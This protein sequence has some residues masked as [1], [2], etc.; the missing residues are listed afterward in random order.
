MSKSSDGIRSKPNSVKIKRHNADWDFVYHGEGD[1]ER[2]LGQIERV[3]YVNTKTG[4]AGANNLLFH[5]HA[6]VPASPGKKE[7]IQKVGSFTTKEKAAAALRKFHQIEEQAQRKKSDQDFIADIIGGALVEADVDDG[8]LLTE[9][10]AHPDYEIEDHPIY[11]KAR[12]MGK[13]LPS[14][15]LQLLYSGLDGAAKR[16][17]DAAKKSSSTVLSNLDS[18]GVLPSR[19]NAELESAKRKNISAQQLHDRVRIF[20]KGL[21]RGQTE[22]GMAV[23]EDHPFKPRLDWVDIPKTQRPENH[24][25]SKGVEE[26]QGFKHPDGSPVGSRGSAIMKAEKAFQKDNLDVVYHGEDRGFSHSSCEMCGSHLGGNRTSLGLLH[27]HKKYKNGVK[28][29]DTIEACD[30]CT[31][32]VAN[33]ELPDED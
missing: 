33:G 10:D 32:Y 7:G 15:K 29:V 31:H 19:G 1:A 9:S 3:Q 2:E 16:A 21:R 28:H 8:V 13:G 27:R 5:A 30:D 26:P 12:A 22:Q 24:W 25:G 4:E 17:S 6:T 18:Q 11:V 14:E 20:Q 23:C